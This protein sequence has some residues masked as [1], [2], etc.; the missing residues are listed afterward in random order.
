MDSLTQ[1]FN[2]YNHASKENPLLG[3]ILIPLLGGIMFYLK[4][5]PGLMWRWFVRNTTITMSLNN[6][7][8]EGNADAYN[9]FDRWFMGTNSISFSRNFF[10]FRGYGGLNFFNHAINPTD[11]RLGVG[12]GTHVFFHER[13]LYWFVKSK[14]P[15]T[16]SS[17]EKEEIMVRTF[18]WNIT[19]FTK[20]VDILNETLKRKTGTRVHKWSVKNSS[21]EYVKE[22]NVPALDTFSMNEEIKQ[23]IL[24]QLDSFYSR[25]EWYA[26]KGLTYKTS[27]LFHGPAG[28]GKTTLS[29]L[30]AGHY[31][32]DLYILDL[33]MLTNDS[34]IEALSQVAPGSI[35]LMEDVDQAGKAVVKRDKDKQ[36]PDALEDFMS[37][38][39]LTMSGM[40]NAFDGVLP[41]HNIVI[42]MTTNHPEVLDPAIRR[43]S[44]ID[45][46]YEI[47]YL[48]DVEVSTYAKKMF[49][50]SDD[51][52]CNFVLRDAKSPISIPGCE[53]EHIFKEHPESAQMFLLNVKMRSDKLREQSKLKLAA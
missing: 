1:I 40:L 5:I 38:Y 4:S 53:M 9:A 7:G 3:L 42:I 22:I 36:T 11:F 50:L 6:A 35:L 49:D 39:S 27:F 45:N 16:G 2:W 8:Y 33:T 23:A 47:N 24:K 19:Q 48:T 12:V 30:L 29:K 15:S 46:E 20:L 34:L 21:W 51:V 37:S 44:R 41:L 31:D 52:L 14:L 18:G 17:T 43:K 26:N 32:K 10:L 13:K 25:K 28:T